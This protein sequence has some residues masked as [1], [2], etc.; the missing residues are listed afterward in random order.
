M[1]SLNQH[2]HKNKRKNTGSKPILETHNSVQPTD[3]EY[4]EPLAKRS[5]RSGRN[6]KSKGGL[7]ISSIKGPMGI[8]SDAKHI[9]SLQVFDNFTPCTNDGATGILSQT[10][11]LGC[12]DKPTASEPGAQAF[13]NADESETADQFG[14]FA[15]GQ[16]RG[17]HRWTNECK[18][19]RNLADSMPKKTQCYVRLAQTLDGD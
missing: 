3:L 11:K 10:S 9:S 15:S 14:H 2:S 16:K 17:K 4:V 13:G 12:Q 19:H 8:D 18:T 6:P 5:R 7:C 1:S